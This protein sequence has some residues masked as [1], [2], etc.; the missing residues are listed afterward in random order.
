MALTTE[1]EQALLGML[2]SFQNGMR[3][4]DLPLATGVVADLNIEVTDNTGESKRINLSEAVRTASSGICGRYWNTTHAT[5]SAAGYHGSLEMLRRL[6][7]LLGLGCYLVADDR[8]RRKLD[9]TNHYFFEDG[10]MAKL[11]GSN[12]Q[13]MWC[14]NGF[15]FA[16]WMEGDLE[17]YAVS[18]TEIKGKKS[19]YIPAGGLSALGGG[20]MDRTNNLLCSVVSD[21]PQFRGGN[22]N[23]A[24]DGTYQTQLGMVATYMSLTN[25]SARARARGEGWEANWYVAQAVPEILFLI[26]FGTR[27][28]Q[29][30]VNAALDANGLRQGGL[31]TGVTDF[32]SWSTFNGAYPVVP[33]SVGIS[34]GDACG[35][36]GYDVLKEDGTVY[37][38]VKVPVFFGLKHPFGHIWKFVRGLIVDVGEVKSEVYVAPSLYQGYNDASTAG[39]LKVS[40]TPR[41]SG[42]IIKKS[43]NLLNAL[44]TQA[45]GSNI[46]Y[47]CDCFWESSASSKGLRV[48]LSGATAGNATN[49]G[50]FASNT[51]NAASHTSTALS[52]PLCYFEEDPA[53][54]L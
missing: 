40:E 32:P 4:E 43:W 44:P 33:T 26:I 19:Y 6:P 15:H 28:S 5:P 24:R 51:N 23:A 36:V 54:A 53:M 2:N 41:A 29:A 25:F 48:R 22:N 30:A 34:L 46:T 3:I 49:A 14:W 20:V 9:P 21:T 35:E 50:T 52:V 8:M 13:Y 12:G 45:G 17:Y 37:K 38:T 1:Q 7:E 47:Y 27:N 10:S 16:T 42:Y 39:L 11:D 31:G 18:L